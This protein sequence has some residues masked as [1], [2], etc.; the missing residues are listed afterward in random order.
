MGVGGLGVGVRVKGVGER[1]A[2]ERWEKVAEGW[3]GLFC[4]FFNFLLPNG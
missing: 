2:Q 4:V 1:D 3:A